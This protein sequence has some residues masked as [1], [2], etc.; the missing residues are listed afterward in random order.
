MIFIFLFH[1]L[2]NIGLLM[3]ATYLDQRSVR[4]VEYTALLTEYLLAIVAIVYE[5]MKA[6]EAIMKFVEALLFIK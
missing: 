2:W 3:T 6:K 1:G 4:I 5:C